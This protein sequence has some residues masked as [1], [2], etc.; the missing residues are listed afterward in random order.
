MSKEKK[1][2][3]TQMTMGGG[4]GCKERP[5]VCSYVGARV[6]HPSQVARNQCV[7][8]L[9]GGGGGGGKEKPASG[10]TAEIQDVFAITVKTAYPGTE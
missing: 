7:K 3:D 10:K 8:L 2:E 5:W 4:F 1:D 9:G 6:Y